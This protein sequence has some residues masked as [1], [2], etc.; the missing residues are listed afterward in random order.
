MVT[1]FTLSNQMS[2]SLLIYLL[3][4]VSDRICYDNI[5]ATS[6]NSTELK[7]DCDVARIKSELLYEI[8]FGSHLSK[9][10]ELFACVVYLSSQES[11]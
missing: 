10:G 7:E 2:V 1:L 9:S 6:V 4:I 11:N 3:E 5:L 8:G